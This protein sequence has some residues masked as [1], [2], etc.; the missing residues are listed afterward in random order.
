MCVMSSELRVSRDLDAEKGPR[1]RPGRI[2]WH[3]R[4]ISYLDHKFGRSTKINIYI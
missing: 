2:S 1:R 3:S 4:R